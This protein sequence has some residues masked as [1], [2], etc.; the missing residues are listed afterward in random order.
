MIGNKINDRSYSKP[1]KEILKNLGVILG[2]FIEN[3]KVLE[4]LEYQVEKRTEDLYTA[5][6]D[7]KQRNEKISKNNTVIKKQNHIFLSLFETST[8][9]HEI[10][11]LNDLFEFTLNQ[12]HFLFPRLGFGIIHEGK[13]PEILES[14]AFIGISANEQKIILK[15][16]Q[17]IDRIDMNQILNKKKHPPDI[18]KDNQ[19]PFWTVLPMQIRD[20][21][22]IGKIII[23]GPR[24]DQ[25]TNK[26]ISIFL[27]Q[28][29]A[30]AHNKF[31]MRKLETIANTDGLTGVA[32]RSFFDQE[33]KKTI[34]N[35]S[36][37]PDIHFSLLI[38]DINGLK[39]INDNFGHAKGDE[40]IKTVADMLAS[41]C[42]ET[43]TLSRMG[44]DEFIILLPATDSNQTLTV[45]NRIRQK[46]K[47]LTLICR[48]SG[49]E[50]VKVPIRISIGLAGSDETAPEKV[51]KRADQRM[52]ID[53]ENFYQQ[54]I[55]NLP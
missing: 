51:M 6:E 9:I 44:G 24:L 31:L 1:E 13:R 28:V 14:G 35:S 30:A 53:K 34:K 2:P 54:T 16:R 3:A 19:V 37:F 43:D 27:A 12:L 49:H 50:A 17:A 42:R 52:Y 55:R 33:L 29:S 15:H 32:N 7:I 26:V 38:I 25:T 40:M 41:V 23:K 48:H 21:R 47:N 18:T 36:M 22:V 8:H 20:N 10:D 4:G 11:E 46:E 45:Q 39:R 5:L